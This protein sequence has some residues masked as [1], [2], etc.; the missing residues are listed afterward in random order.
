MSDQKREEPLHNVDQAAAPGL[1]GWDVLL[2]I[3]LTLA[4]LMIG[5]FAESGLGGR[6]ADVARHP[7]LGQLVP[8]AGVAAMGEIGPRPAEPLGLLLYA[9]TIA[10][11]ILYALVDLAL[12]GRWQWRLKWVLLAGVLLTALYLPT[13]KFMLLDAQGPRGSYSHDGGVLQTEATIVFFLQGK[14]PYREDYTATPMA[15]WGHPD[16]RTALYHY[17]YL[18]W[19]FL[20]ST[21]FYLIGNALGF[22]DQRLVYLLLLAI[23]LFLAPRL[24]HQPRH[25]VALVMLIGLNPL[26]ALDIMFGQNDVFVFCWLFFAL[27]A[28][29][30]WYSVASSGGSPPTAPNFGEPRGQIARLIAVVAF[31]AACASKPTAWFFAP[32]F[33]LLLL[34]DQ[35]RFSL[36]GRGLLRQSMRLI[37]RGWPALLLFMLC[38]GPYLLWDPFAIYDDVWRWSN[39]QGETGY[40]IWGWGASNFVLAMGLVA[41]R[42]GLWPFW[43]I[44]VLLALPTL[45]W[46]LWRQVRA[47]TLANA[48]W[49]YGLFLLI[50]FYGSRFLNENYLAFILTFLALG[51]ITASTAGRTAGS[52]PRGHP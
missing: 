50:F 43:R 18:P 47:N 33:G 26:M 20:F 5:G 14:N 45:L 38:I 31:G 12:R 42:F 25:K 13:L 44:E 15:T 8:A 7:L 19:T 41:D 28:W 35:E 51:I 16:F 48:C 10:L 32:F 39:G 27:V 6:F 9:T 17:P 37:R 23:A 40:Q 11:L 52:D 49:H 34:A 3:L 46:F 2:L 22:Y 30:R 29:H 36:T 4:I 21:P 1:P 24:A